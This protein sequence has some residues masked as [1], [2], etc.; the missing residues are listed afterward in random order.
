MA[1]RDIGGRPVEIR[2]IGEGTPVLFLH[3]FGPDHRSLL[4]SLGPVFERRT[5]YR[6]IHV[7]LPG[8][9]TS[10]AARD[11]D[12][13]DAMVDF[14]LELVDELV[15]SEPLLLVGESW[16]GYLARGVAA[17]R[18]G[19]VRGIAL[20]VT[21]VIAK[22]EDRDVPEQALLFEEPGILD[23]VGPIDA[24][25]FRAA[26]V[27]ADRTSLDFVRSTILPAV[28]VIDEEAS[29]RIAA[30]YAFRSDVDGGEPFAGPSL[31]VSGRH[32]SVVGWRDSLRLLERFPRSTYAVLDAAGHN[33]EGERAGLLRE[34]VDDWLD[35]VERT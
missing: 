24:A 30:Q 7:D 17:R 25:A 26:A 21:V 29:D 33:L 8:F 6:R 28:A 22:H 14:V 5:G 12:S 34:L 9:G 31:I 13:S 3:G 16:G 20:I 2:E 10:P 18:P 4:W 27:V 1:I 15:G 35:R 23:G 19:Q 32:D 11:I